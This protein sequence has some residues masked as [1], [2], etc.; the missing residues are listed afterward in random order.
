LRIL[1]EQT[2]HYV[3]ERGEKT[4][5]AE[6]GECRVIGLNQGR[7]FVEMLP[8]QFRYGRGLEWWMT[9]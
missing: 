2:V 7:D 8:S 1:C 5:A 9:R 3:I 6:R 4:G